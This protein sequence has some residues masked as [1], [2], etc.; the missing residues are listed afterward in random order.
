MPKIKTIYRK[1]H[2]NHLIEIKVYSGR[3]YLYVDGIE[4]DYIYRA[5]EHE[6]KYVLDERKTIKIIINNSII[7]I[8]ADI[9][10]N[11]TQIDYVDKL[12]VIEES[13]L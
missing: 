11:N 7:K 10:E 9:Y 1:K 13:N 5:T 12:R 8:S 2:D 6:L 3:F 4:R